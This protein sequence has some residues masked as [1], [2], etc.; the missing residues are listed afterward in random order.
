MC[1]EEMKKIGAEPED[2]GED[3]TGEIYFPTV[4]SLKSSQFMERQIGLRPNFLSLGETTKKIS[5]NNADLIKTVI[6]FIKSDT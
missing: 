6:P 2:E 4:L 3:V 1:T 5:A